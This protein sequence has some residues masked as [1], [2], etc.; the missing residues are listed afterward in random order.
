MTIVYKNVGLAGHI[1]GKSDVF[2]D[3]TGVDIVTHEIFITSIA[4]AFLRSELGVNSSNAFTS[5]I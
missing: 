2:G 1:K 4:I 3:V 5:V